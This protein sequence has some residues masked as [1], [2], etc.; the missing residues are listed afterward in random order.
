[1]SSILLI[2]FFRRF[3]FLL[4]E[5]AVLLGDTLRAFDSSVSGGLSGPFIE[6]A[7]PRDAAAWEGVA[8]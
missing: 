4:P 5:S 8:H 6:G 2:F 3:C 1:M 7:Y